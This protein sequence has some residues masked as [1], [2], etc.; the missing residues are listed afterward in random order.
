MIDDSV[1]ESMIT[2]FD[3]NVYQQEIPL[4]ENHESMKKA[5]G[6]FKNLYKEDDGLY[7]DVQINTRGAEIMNESIYKYVSI[8]FYIDY[9]PSKV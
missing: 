6:R 2:N 5:I 3:N 7:G 8:E 1:I 9:V 4:N